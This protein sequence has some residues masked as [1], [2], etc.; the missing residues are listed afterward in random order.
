MEG[1]EL[2]FEAEGTGE[3]IV[4]IAQQLAWLGAALRHSLDDGLKNSEAEIST[5]QGRKPVFDVTFSVSPLNKNESSC[6]HSLFTSSVIDKGFPI[7][8]R[9][10]EVGLEI[11][12]EMMAALTGHFHSV[13]GGVSFGRANY[14]YL[15]TSISQSQITTTC[16]SF[17]FNLPLNPHIMILLSELLER[18]LKNCQPFASFLIVL[19]ISLI[20]AQYFYTWY[21]LRHIKGP[22]LASLSKLWLIRKVSGGRMH[23][24]FQ[25]VCEKYGALSTYQVMPFKNLLLWRRLMRC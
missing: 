10:Q 9:G 7:A 16:R 6:W 15:S 5:V 20:I 24:D 11:P 17:P 2:I 8:E 12:L 23:L 4:E 19:S 18:G 22:F 21:H 13:W 3:K 1:E 25:E 14:S